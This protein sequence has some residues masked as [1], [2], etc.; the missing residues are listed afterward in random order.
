MFIHHHQKRM[1]SSSLRTLF[2][3]IRSLN[4]NT[5]VKDAESNTQEL[6]TKLSQQEQVPKQLVSQLND[7]INNKNHSIH[8]SIF[9][10]WKRILYLLPY[11]KSIESLF[12]LVVYLCMNVVIH[13]FQEESL[14][15]H[16]R[17]QIMKDVTDIT[18][19]NNSDPVVLAYELMRY[20]S[21]VLLVMIPG[22]DQRFPVLVR[23]YPI[24]NTT[25]KWINRIRKLILMIQIF[26]V[27]LFIGVLYLTSSK[28]IKSK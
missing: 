19:K 9:K 28:L 18:I 6:V 24:I 4:V 5:M 12:Q 1:Y 27:L 17:E 20:Y 11:S 21:I 22:L 13:S 15:V 2:K 10:G 23:L 3:E 7:M 14:T 8:R 16:Q 26:I 25:F